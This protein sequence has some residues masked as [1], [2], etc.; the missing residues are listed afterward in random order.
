VLSHDAVR[1]DGAISILVNESG[2]GILGLGSLREQLGD[3]WPGW[4]G[5]LL[6]ERLRAIIALPGRHMLPDQGIVVTCEKAPDYQNMGLRRLT[7]RPMTVVD[8]LTPREHEIARLLAKGNSHK[9]VA[10]LLGVAPST[11]RNQTQ[12]IYDK[13]GIGSRAELAS[14]F[15]AGHTH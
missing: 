6:P 14:L 12:S 4:R 1:S 13:A 11:V 15:A 7:I 8:L 10:R 3:F 5:D 9:D 2:I